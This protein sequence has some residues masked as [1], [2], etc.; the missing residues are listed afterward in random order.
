ME[1]GRLVKIRVGIE[2]GR[3][4]VINRAIEINAPILVS[5]NS[6]WDNER[7]KFSG[8]AA[9][10]KN[11]VAL[12]SGGFV[13]MKKYGGYRWTIGDY[14]SLAR[15]VNPTWWA[16][17]DF[18]CEPEIAAS[19]DEIKKR[20]KKTAEY[21]LQCENEAAKKETNPPM[22]VLQGWKPEDY[23]NGPI[24]DGRKWP[25]LVGIGSVCRRNVHG[26]TGILSVIDALNSAVPEGV[27]FHLFGVKS[28]AIEILLANFPNRIASIDS[29]AWNVQAR[30]Q[31][32]KMKTRCTGLDRANAMSGWYLRQSE[33]VTKPKQK[34][35]T[36]G[37]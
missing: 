24:Y 33:I 1:R 28:Q 29:M 6:L 32:F 23:C 16:Q 5:A 7:K 19:H 26:K 18:C 27:Q 9:Y 20:I 10:E 36:F 15:A 11:D 30:W 22:P 4:P 12:D 34:T 2:G 8:W 14:V 21:L 31:S 25:K 3:K 35:F 13:A 37:A 17:M